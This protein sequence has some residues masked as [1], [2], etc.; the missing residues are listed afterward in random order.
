MGWEILENSPL[1]INRYRDATAALGYTGDS[2]WNS[3]GDLA[4]A[5]LGFWLAWKLPVKATVAVIVIIELAMLLTI[6]DNL[7]LNIVMLLY[8]IDAI[9]EWQLR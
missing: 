6:K 4:C 5:A 2:I 8:P 1:I 9:K 3:F 7:T